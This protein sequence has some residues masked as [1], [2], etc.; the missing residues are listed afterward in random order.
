M[1]MMVEETT[2]EQGCRLDVDRNGDVWWSMTELQVLM[3]L[4]V[5]EVDGGVPVGEVR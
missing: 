5:L 1:T 3:M 2:T 4:E